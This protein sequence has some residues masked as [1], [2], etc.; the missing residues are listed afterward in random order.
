GRNALLVDVQPLLRAS[1]RILRAAPA[2]V[3]LAVFLPGV[4]AAPV[5]MVPVFAAAGALRAEVVVPGLLLLGIGERVVGVD[6]RG[7]LDHVLVE[8]DV[9]GVTVEGRP[10]ERDEGFRHAEQ[11]GCHADESRM[12]AIVVDKYLLDRSDL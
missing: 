1:H 2:P 11:A 4:F 9:Y 7:V 10:L 12:A 8:G 6:S 3:A 5:L